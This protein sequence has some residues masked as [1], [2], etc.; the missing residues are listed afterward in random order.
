M[1]SYSRT[2]EHRLK[3]ARIRVDPWNPWL[4]FGGRNFTTTQSPTAGACHLELSDHWGFSGV[5]PLAFWSF[6]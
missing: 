6:D 5:W 1:F 2:D 4:K 3:T